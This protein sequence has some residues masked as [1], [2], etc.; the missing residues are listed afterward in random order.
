MLP[1]STGLK[2]RSFPI[3]TI[4]II[5]ANLAVWL[6]YELPNLNAA[7]AQASFYPGTVDGSYDG[8]LPSGISWFTSMFL[9]GS[10]SHILGNMLFLAV[11]GK[12]VE[13]AFGHLRYLGFYIAGGFV[14][15]AAQTAMTL[16]A[17]TNADGAVPNLGAS[18][19]IAA[20]LGAY[21]VLFPGSR[22]FGLFGIFP[23]TISAWF[24]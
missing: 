20:V 23:V 7:I 18:G 12:G 13:D 10:W 1:L 22:V 9:D 11:F 5:A 19:A 21:L 17:G 6:F 14:A 16:L 8:P 3:V 15:T 24:F 2:A 4:A